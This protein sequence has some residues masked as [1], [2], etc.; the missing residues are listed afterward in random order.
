M[1]LQANHQVIIHGADKTQATAL[2]IE[3]WTSKGFTVHSSSYN[4]IVLHR[5]GYGSIGKRLGNLF[6]GLVSEVKELSWDRIPT[7]LTVLCQVL[8]KEAKWDLAFKLASGYSEKNPGDFSS[9]SCSWCNEFADFCR[10]W[11]DNANV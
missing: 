9:A 3:Y 5:N 1:A 2:A 4:C 11:M 6:N 8:P 7:E 10:Q